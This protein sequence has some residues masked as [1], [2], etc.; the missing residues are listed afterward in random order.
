MFQRELRI[1]GPGHSMAAFPRLSTTMPIY[2]SGS[3]SLASPAAGYR[4]PWREILQLVRSRLRRWFA[5]DLAC[6][7]VEARSNGWALSRHRGAPASSISQRGSNAR[8]A[9]MAVQDG[10]YRKAIQALTSEGLATPCPEVI[11]EMQIKHTQA[12]PP[13]LP[14]AQYHHLLGSL[15][16]LSAGE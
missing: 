10:Q 16:L 15:S 11:Q 2:R 6:L 4:L 3:G 14:P 7:W 9:K 5:G 12:T 13:T 1:V 8:R